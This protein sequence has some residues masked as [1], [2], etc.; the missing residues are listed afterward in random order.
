MLHAIRQNWPYAVV[1]LG[2]LGFVYCAQYVVRFG[3]PIAGFSIPSESMLPTLQVGDQIYC[4]KVTDP[5][6]VQPGEVVLFK[7]SS[8][9]DWVKRVVAVGGQKFAMKN[10]IV[11]IDGVL[12]TQERAGEI[13]ERTATG[14]SLIPQFREY[15]PGRGAGYA[16]LAVPRNSRRGEFAPVTVPG[17]H[18]FVIGDN[19]DNSLDSRTPAAEK[20]VGP[21][22]LD[23]IEW[24]N[25][26]VF[27]S[28]KTGRFF[29]K[30]R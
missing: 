19:R 11:E 1:G 29:S 9:V 23:R 13:S 2:F 18:V 14:W 10:G 6:V 15:L 26:M 25:C 16:V 20:G 3:R 12:A 8:G 22:P 4:L 28:P 27:V 17:G 7:H 30:V 21:L 24:H 5:A